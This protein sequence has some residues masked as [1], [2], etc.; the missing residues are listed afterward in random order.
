[1]GRVID[2]NGSRT[3][4]VAIAV[5]A[6]AAACGTGG[7][8]GATASTAA[9]GGGAGTASGEVKVTG[10]STVQPISQAVSEAFADAN[11]D[12]GYVVEGPGT[13][14]GF[15]DF[16]CTGEYDVADASRAI[17]EEEAAACEE[18]GVE[19]VELQ[20][21]YDGITVFTSP[22]TVLE[23]VTLPDLYALFGPESSDF[24]TWQDAG[25]LAEE[26]GSTTQFPTGDLSITA[27][28]EESGT[29]SS[30]IEL[31]LGDLIEE[32][33][34]E[35]A[36]G[37]H[38][39]PSPD[40]NVIVENV[41]GTP[42][43]LGFAGFSFYEANQERLKAVPVDTGEGC[44]S[45]TAETISDGSYGLS[46]PLFIYPS[47]TKAAESPALVAWVDYYLSDEGIANVATTGYVDLPADEL[48]ATRQAWS[49]AKP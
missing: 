47:L 48:E 34:Q 20:V 29:Y 17:D 10:S 9:T 19:Y 43:S 11:P 3:V 25:A 6:I 22:D 39:T 27:P 35:E 21:A 18:A 32:R 30:F 7:T 24:T 49:D 13:G 14:D 42:N 4:A 12:F 38:Y 33:G 41:A 36:L 28:G 8:A 1:M 31:A 5:L 46:R 23:C 15:D 40:D 26:L 37:T 45:P 16:F 44:A 2:R